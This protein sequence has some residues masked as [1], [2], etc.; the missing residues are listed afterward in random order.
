LAE[1]AKS[2]RP[3]NALPVL[4]KV[5][6]KLL[7]PRLLEITERQKIIPNHQFGFRHRHATIEQIYTI[8]KKI[9]T[10]MDAG[11][12][13][14]AVFLEVSQAFDKVWHAGLH[15]I[16]NCF[17]LDLY[18]IIK[19]YLLQRIFKVKFGEVE[20]WQLKDINS[21]V[22]SVLGPV[23]SAIY[24]ISFS[25]PGYHNRNL[26]RRYSYPDGSQRPYRSIPAFTKKP[27]PHPDMAK[28]MEN[29]SQ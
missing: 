15:K 4:S 25:Y 12:Y 10:D 13:C 9:N 8:V 19:S 21:G 22:P 24:R 23:L 1:L 27:I 7:L 20:K 18:A 11:T 16:K 28:K 2:Y 5:F 14:T 26:Y 6:E 3:I 17:P 29:Q